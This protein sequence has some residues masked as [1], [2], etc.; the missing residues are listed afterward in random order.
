[1]SKAEVHAAREA[2]Y[3]HKH[4]NHGGHYKSGC[5]LCKRLWEAYLAASRAAA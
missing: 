2:Y 1:M 3:D 4:A 5:E